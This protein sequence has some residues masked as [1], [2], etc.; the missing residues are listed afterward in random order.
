M[1]RAVQRGPGGVLASG[2]IT[3]RRLREEVIAA[4][5]SRRMTATALQRASGL[6]ARTLRD[7]E[8][9]TP[10]RRYSVTT[11]AALDRAFGWDEG[12]AWRLWQEDEEAAEATTPLEELAAQM[13]RLRSEV[14]RQMTALRTEEA[15]HHLVPSWAVEVVDLMRLMSAEDRRRILDLASRL[16]PG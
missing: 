11:L 8:G 10:G 5:T 4:R 16:A 3:S 13:E 6:S 9:G 12:R 1:G 7:I 15:D 14:R 2:R